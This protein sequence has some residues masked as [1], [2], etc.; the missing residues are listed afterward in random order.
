MNDQKKIVLEYT[1][2]GNIWRTPYGNVPRRGLT[3]DEA[4]RYGGVSALARSPLYKKPSK[5]SEPP[6]DTLPEDKNELVSPKGTE[7]KAEV[8]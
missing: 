7:E 2:N 4:K 6:V 8:K 1:G 5:I 3:A